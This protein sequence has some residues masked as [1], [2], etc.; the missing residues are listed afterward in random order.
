VNYIKANK[1]DAAFSMLLAGRAEYLL[2]YKDPSETALQKIS[3]PDLSYNQISA[4][5]CYFVISRKTRGG[6]AILDRL[7][8]SYAKLKAQGEVR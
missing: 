7:E 8:K 1:H 6:Q 5:P 4:L 2:D 3:I